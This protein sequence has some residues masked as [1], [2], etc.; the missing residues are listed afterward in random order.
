MEKVG[1]GYIGT[2]PNNVIIKLNRLHESRDEVTAEYQLAYKKAGPG[3]VLDWGRINLMSSQARDRMAKSL[4]ERRIDLTVE[5]DWRAHIDLFFREVLRLERLGVPVTTT[6]GDGETSKP[7][8]YILDPILPEG[9]VTILFGAGGVGKSTLAAAIAFSVQTGR[10]LFR[11]WKPNSAPV[12][13]LDWEASL[14]RWQ[15]TFKA[16]GRGYGFPAPDVLYRE[17]KRRLADDLESIA[18]AIDKAS[19][20]LVIVDSAGLAFGNSAAE[21]DKAES[22]MRAFGAIRETSQCAWIVIDHQTGDDVRQG[23]TA[24]K[25]Y[26]SV[27]KMNLARMVF[28][29]E[30]EKENEEARQELLLKNIKSNYARLLKPMGLACYREEGGIRYEREDILEAPELAAGMTAGQRILNALFLAPDNAATPE[31]LRDLLGID[32]KD[33]RGRDRLHL[34][35]HR[36]IKKGILVKL[37]DG[38]VGRSE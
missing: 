26:G 15:D 5:T 28:H 33:K 27:Y 38:R 19:V 18:D 1:L 30:G 23:G 37:P 3:G 8:Q 20:G 13:I 35:I 11:G 9:L 17:C 24:A 29:L 6:N 7:L 36:M 22:T 2:F 31:R 34:A 32:D 14:W 21:G 12:L 4:N 25:P 16:L 10:E